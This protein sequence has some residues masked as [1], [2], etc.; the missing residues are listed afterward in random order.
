MEKM[1]A[2]VEEQSPLIPDSVPVETQSLAKDR[3]KKI[4]DLCNCV[5]FDRNLKFSQALTFSALWFE[6]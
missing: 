6:L 2:S 3:K 4:I 5:F 1:E